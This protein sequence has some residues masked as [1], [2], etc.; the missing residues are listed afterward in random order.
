M[1][2]I[3]TVG[4]APARSRNSH[5]TASDEAPINH[6]IGRATVAIALHHRRDE[7]GQRLGPMQ[8]RP[9]RHQLADDQRR[10]GE[11]NDEDRQPDRLGMLSERTATAIG[12]HH[13]QVVDNLLTAIRRAKRAHQRDADLH[14]RQ[15]PIRIARQLQ[16]PLR[17]AAA[18][19]GALFEPAPPGGDDRNLGR[20]KEAV[21][22][23]QHEDE[24]D[25]PDI[26]AVRQIV[27]RQAASLVYSSTPISRIK[28]FM[29]SQQSFFAAGLRSRYAG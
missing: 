2:S 15:K 5:S 1:S 20:G 25:F 22:Q 18:L 10:I 13:A 23:N 28:N 27:D 21:G 11:A 26:M 4:S 9:L 19:F 16:R 8:R 24:Q 14:R 6:T 12:D 29:S 7:H 3:D 17:V